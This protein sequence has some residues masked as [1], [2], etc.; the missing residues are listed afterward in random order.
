M[1]FAGGVCKQCKHIESLGLDRNTPDA[2]KF[3]R[4]SRPNFIYEDVVLQEYQKPSGRG[5]NWRILHGRC[6]IIGI[7][8]TKQSGN[9]NQHWPLVCHHIG[10]GDGEPWSLVTMCNSNINVGLEYLEGDPKA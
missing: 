5:Y 1:R 2:Y 10:Y 7:G 6:P 4:R 9:V 3:K 8:G